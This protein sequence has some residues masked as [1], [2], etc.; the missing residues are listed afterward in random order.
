M[1]QKSISCPGETLW[2][3][4]RG[5]IGGQ[6]NQH[7]LKIKWYPREKIRFEIF[8]QKKLIQSKF[9]PCQSHCIENKHKISNV[10]DSMWVKQKVKAS[11]SVCQFWSY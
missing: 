7:L 11:K 10:K 6:Q 4:G 5:G 3:H 8:G 2:H 9:D 1:V